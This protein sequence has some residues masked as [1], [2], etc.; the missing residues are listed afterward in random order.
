MDVLLLMILFAISRYPTV[1]PLNVKWRLLGLQSLSRTEHV[2]V[3]KD[4]GRFLIGIRVRSASWVSV[5][6][7]GRTS[8]FRGPGSTSRFVAKGPGSTSRFRIGSMACP[9]VQGQAHGVPQGSGLGP[10]RTPTF[11][12]G[13][14]VYLKVHGKGPR[15]TPSFKKWIRTSLLLLLCYHIGV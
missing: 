2:K 8:R 7:P 12:F 10:G 11:R 6:G 9:K 3:E 1:E 5:S 4:Y 14:R 15:G 13:A